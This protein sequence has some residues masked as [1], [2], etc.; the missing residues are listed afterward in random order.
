MNKV[1]AIA[2]DVECSDLYDVIGGDLLEMSFV[3]ILSTPEGLKKGRKTCIRSRAHNPK[4]FNDQSQ[5][6]HGISYWKAMEFQSKEDSVEEFIEWIEPIKDQ[7]PFEMVYHGNGNFDHR[8]L[9]AHFMKVGKE[10]IFRNLMPQE[11]TVS[12]L[13]LS[14]KF[15]KHIQDYKIW[16]PVKKKHHGLYALPNVA[17]H[18]GIP[19]E[20]HRSLSDAEACAQI[21]INVKEKRDIYTGELDF[22]I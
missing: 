15:L 13:Q 6:I 17:R 20:H 14:R 9:R 2:N 18:Y 11:R 19:L 16:C 3:E 22:E 7:G 5:K 12:T 8:W 1:V 21:Y 10:D 4:Y